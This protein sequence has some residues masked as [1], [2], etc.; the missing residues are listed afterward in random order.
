[1]N[2]KIRVRRMIAHGL[3]EEVV[4]RAEGTRVGEYTRRG[5]SG[6]GRGGGSGGGS[7]GERGE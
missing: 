6:G 5:A 4:D 2:K 1:M 3:D 7:G